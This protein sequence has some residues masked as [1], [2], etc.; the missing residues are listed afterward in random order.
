[1]IQLGTIDTRTGEIQPSNK[2]ALQKAIGA[3]YQNRN[4]IKFSQQEDPSQEIV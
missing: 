3:Y 4:A 2:D 1:M